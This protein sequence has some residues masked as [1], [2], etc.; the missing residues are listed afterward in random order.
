MFLE[1]FLSFAQHVSD[2]TEPII[3]STTVVYAAICFRCVVFYSLRLV[4]VFCHIAVSR[5]VLDWLLLLLLGGRE[6]RLPLCER[7]YGRERERESS[8]RKGLGG[9]GS[10]SERRCLH[11]CCCGPNRTVNCCEDFQ[12]MPA[13]PS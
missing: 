9:G 6:Q 2:L 3:R 10:C 13:R 11:C 8:N 12:A 1:S 7:E 5:S 4:L